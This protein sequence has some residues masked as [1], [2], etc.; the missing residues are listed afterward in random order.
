[1]IPH[2]VQLFNHLQDLFFPKVQSL[3][4]YSFHDFFSIEQSA[5]VLVKHEELVMQVF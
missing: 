4:L 1:M 5:S 2:V 3:L